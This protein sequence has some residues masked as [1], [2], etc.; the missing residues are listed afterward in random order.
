MSSSHGWYLPLLNRYHNT[1]IHDSQI[2]FIF[3]SS[4]NNLISTS[5]PKSKI[6]L[7]IAERI[8]DYCHNDKNAL[9]NCALVCT[10]WIRPAR[11]HLINAIKL[12]RGFVDKFLLA[13]T[14]PGSRLGTSIRSLDIS[15]IPATIPSYQLNEA[16]PLLADHLPAVKTLSL[17]GLDWRILDIQ[18]QACFVHAFPRL[19]RLDIIQCR[20]Q[21]LG[22]LVEYVT[23]FPDLD[24]LRV[25][26]S[27]WDNRLIPTQLPKLFLPRLKS[28]LLY[29]ADPRIIDLLDCR[30]LE[31]I[32]LD[33]V[34]KEHI[35]AVRDLLHRVGPALRELRIRFT[36]NIYVK[37]ALLSALTI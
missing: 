21:A 8:I 22:Q 9:A 13:L 27:Q 11:Y 19:V 34:T 28:L 15:N 16:I 17:A 3:R 32:S 18:V 33:D 10:A 12:R 5:I 6:P 1:A 24:S 29:P 35:P 7:E 31:M 30:D 20:F 23:S 25:N 14:S 4:S 36:D 2:Q 26:K 37:G